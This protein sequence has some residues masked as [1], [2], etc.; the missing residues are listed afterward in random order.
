[1]STS[2][3]ALFDQAAVLLRDGQIA[4]A[5][6]IYARVLQANPSDPGALH[7]SGLIAAQTGQWERAANL[8]KQSLD[9]DPSDAEAYCNLGTVYKMLGRH[10]DALECYDRAIEAAPDTAAV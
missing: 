4:E 3:E 2:A 6:S 10:S 7:F 1:M 5:D 8:M 9:H